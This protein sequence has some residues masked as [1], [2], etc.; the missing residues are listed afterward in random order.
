M[1]LQTE[2]VLID[3][4]P[5][6]AIYNRH[7][8]HH[9]ACIERSKQLGPH[10]FTCWPV[11]TEACYLLRK[12][13]DLIA[14]LLEACN[15]GVFTLLP[16]DAADI[17]EIGG[18]L[19]KYPDHAIDLADATLAALAWREG[20]SHVFTVDRTHFRLFRDS[21]GQSFTLLPLD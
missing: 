5:L 8:Q 3:T 21:K 14:N 17:P 11:L 20:I 18:V 15:E 7:D 10:V 6:A 13:P 9:H 2:K 16:L 19:A 1:N 12:R 4:G